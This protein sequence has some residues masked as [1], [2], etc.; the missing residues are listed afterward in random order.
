MP[1]KNTR[2]AGGAEQMA[3]RSVH[4][5]VPGEPTGKGRPRVVRLPNGASHTYTPEKTAAYERRVQHEYWRQTNCA[6]FADGDALALKIEA[7]CGIPKNASRAKRAAMESGALRPAKKPDIDNILKAVAD[8]LNTI[9]YRDDTQIVDARI[10]KMYSH[11]PR[12]EVT[13]ERMEA[14]T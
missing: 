10:R 6:R 7:Y 1:D 3:I 2:P 4:F 11:E 5:V 8:A 12:A 13:I 14:T 9:A